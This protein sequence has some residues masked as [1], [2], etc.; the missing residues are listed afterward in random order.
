[1]ET[2]VNEAVDEL[3]NVFSVDATSKPAVDTFKKEIA[4]CRKRVQETTDLANKVQSETNNINEL[5][6]SLKSKD[7]ELQTAFDKIDQLELL[8]NRVKDTYNAVAENLDQVEKAV[9]AS[10]PFR[11]VMLIYI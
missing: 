6:Q 3:A 2:I 11:L 1:M 8:I 4:S 9:N 10:T 7:Q 5:L